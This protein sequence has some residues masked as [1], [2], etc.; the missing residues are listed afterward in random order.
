MELKLEDALDEF[1]A[2]YLESYYQVTSKLAH[3]FGLSASQ[4][5]NSQNPERLS[6]PLLVPPDTSDEEKNASLLS[7]PMA[8]PKN[9]PV[10]LHHPLQSSRLQMPRPASTSCSPIGHS[11]KTVWKKYT[12]ETATELNLLNDQVNVDMVI[13]GLPRPNVTKMRRLLLAP[14][15]RSKH[16]CSRNP[17]R[18]TL[19]T[20]VGNPFYRPKNLPR[21]K[22]NQPMPDSSIK[23]S[24]DDSTGMANGMQ[25]FFSN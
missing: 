9:P 16:L 24:L 25:A 11:T 19:A 8:P 7:N 20:N 3:S 13:V 14:S 15:I 22:C 21:K 6:S 4:P 17:R 2:R 23:K 5:P 1:D 18:N 12:S 10:S